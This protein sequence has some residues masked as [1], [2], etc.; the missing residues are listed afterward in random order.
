VGAT[1]H[2]RRAGWKARAERMRS[3][4]GAGAAGG[5]GGGGGGGYLSRRLPVLYFGASRHY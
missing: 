3:H 1:G 2:G 4:R 5:G